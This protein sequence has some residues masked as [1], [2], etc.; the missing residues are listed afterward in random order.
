MYYK[1]KEKNIMNN[2]K[3]YYEF[4]IFENTRNDFKK[5]RRINQIGSILLYD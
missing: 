5:T 3:S 2:N 1:I 4:S